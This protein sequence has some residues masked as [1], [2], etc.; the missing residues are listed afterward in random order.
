MVAVCS[1]LKLFSEERTE[2]ENVVALL[3]GPVSQYV[4][5]RVDDFV[6]QP[7]RWQQTLYRFE[8]KLSG[9]RLRKDVLVFDM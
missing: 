8:E 5:I 6:P 2:D 9:Y 1:A 3:T 4:E 7:S